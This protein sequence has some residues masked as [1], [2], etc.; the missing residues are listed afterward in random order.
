MPRT[1]DVRK[2]FPQEMRQ[3]LSLEEIS[4]AV[5]GLQRR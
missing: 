1:G 3:E 2:G 4:Q 5:E